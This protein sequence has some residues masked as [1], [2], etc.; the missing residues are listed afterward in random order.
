MTAA[1]A[2]P[3]RTPEGLRAFR[4]VHGLSQRKLADLLGMKWDGTISRYENGQLPIPQ[5][6]EM[7]LRWLDHEL[8]VQTL[9]S[10]EP[11]PDPAQELMLSLC[12]ESRDD[13]AN[14][15]LAFREPG[16]AADIEAALTGNKHA[17]IRLRK[18]CGLPAFSHV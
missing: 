5:V 4:H 2:L 14:I 16:N 1:A 18:A 3:L 9:T 13:E 15:M 10:R 11:E 6:V 17:M 8:L 12:A 7:A